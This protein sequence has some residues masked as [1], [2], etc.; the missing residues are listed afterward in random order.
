LALERDAQRMARDVDEAEDRVATAVPVL[1]Q[2]PTEARFGKDGME[3][4]SPYEHVFHGEQSSPK[5]LV[6]HHHRPR[7]VDLGR[8]RFDVATRVE[9]S[10]GVY[11]GYWRLVDE[12][13]Q[14]ITKPGGGDLKKFSTFWPDDWTR[15]QIEQA[16]ADAYWDAVTHGA[17]TADGFRGRTESGHPVRGYFDDHG[18]FTAYLD[19]PKHWQMGDPFP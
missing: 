7:G 13:G 2:L 5:D 12:S 10:D 15:D 6:G 11:A 19:Y 17:K 8:E 4:W 1:R 16:I 14:V 18:I 3:G 9:R